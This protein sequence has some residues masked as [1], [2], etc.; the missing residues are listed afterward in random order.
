MP[1]DGLCLDFFS[2]FFLFF[3]GG[4]LGKSFIGNISFFGAQIFRVVWTHRKMRAPNG[5]VA[6][7]VF[8]LL[9]LTAP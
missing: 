1:L 4:L 6:E 3:E 9:F 2:G 7:V 8:L 5:T